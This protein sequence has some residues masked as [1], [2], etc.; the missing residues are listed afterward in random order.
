MNCR[1]CG[2]PILTRRQ[3][4][5]ADLLLRGYSDSEIAKEL[6]ISYRTAKNYMRAMYQRYDI[7]EGCRRIKLAV[8]LYYE[9]NPEKRIHFPD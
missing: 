6:K 8:T 1:C 4:D 5:C 3:K 9:R 7:R 2:A